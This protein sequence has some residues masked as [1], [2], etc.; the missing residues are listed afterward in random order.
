MVDRRKVSRVKMNRKSIDNVRLA[1]AD[2]TAAIG[3]AI[4]LAADVPDAEPY[5][6]GLVVEGGTLTYVGGKKVG[7]WHQSGEEPRKPKAMKVRGK[8]T[9][10][11]A[12]GWSFPAHLLE[13][14]TVRMG[15]QPFA[16]PA[17]NEVEPRAAG[18][19]RQAAAYRIARTLRK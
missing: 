7:S 10:Q 11:T 19:M 17:R 12:T 3:K 6:V 15:A 14:G 2:G 8:D 5:G 18:I 16:T 9:I 13:F 4:I 1:I